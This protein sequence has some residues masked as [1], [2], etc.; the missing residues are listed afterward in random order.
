MDYGLIIRSGAPQVV[1]RIVS[2]WRDMGY[3]GQ[4]RSIAVFNATDVVPNQLRVAPCRSCR[5][6]P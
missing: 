4:R 3:W 5:E 2:E 1:S 6:S